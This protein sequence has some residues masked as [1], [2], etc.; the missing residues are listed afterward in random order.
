MNG[1]A[2]EKVCCITLQSPAAKKIVPGLIKKSAKQL[3]KDASQ[4]IKSLLTFQD[5]KII[6]YFSP[7]IGP[8]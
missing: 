6:P 1:L 3:L 7:N 5:T 2:L 4:T 8:L